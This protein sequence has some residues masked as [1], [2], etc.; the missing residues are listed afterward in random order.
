M[1]GDNCTDN[2]CPHLTYN[3]SA[4]ACEEDELCGNFFNCYKTDTF[5]IW[6]FPPAVKWAHILNRCSIMWADFC[7]VVNALCVWPLWFN[8]FVP[9]MTSVW[10]LDKICP[11]GLIKQA[12]GCENK[13]LQ[14]P[15]QW[16]RNGFCGFQSIVLKVYSVT[17]FLNMR[18]LVCYKGICQKHVLEKGVLPE[19]VHVSRITEL[20]IHLWPTGHQL[21]SSSPYLYR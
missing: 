8:G 12:V 15:L 10:S 6:I 11:E 2:L 13:V 5:W 1:E 7:N 17:T 18:I 19:S 14:N 4:S 16:K 3:V 9:W 21:N 20:M